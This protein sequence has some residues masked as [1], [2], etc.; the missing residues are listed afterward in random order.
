MRD[1]EKVPVVLVAANQDFLND[2][3]DALVDTNLALLHAQTKTEA[4]TLL[5]RLT[6]E[7]HLAIVEL[8]L[9]DFGAWDLIRKL[10]FEKP[11]KIIATTSTY[12]E[13]HFERIK[14]LG[15][16][17][18]VPTAIPP[19]EWVKTVEAVLATTTSASA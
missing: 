1:S 19:E 14:G 5:E 18:V 12:P 9:P 15:V 17:A 4:I 13:Q 2:L 10:T 11:L 3:R 8:E 7:I 16:D 6:S